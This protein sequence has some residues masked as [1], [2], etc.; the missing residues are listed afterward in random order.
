MREKPIL[1]EK[2][3]ALETAIKNLGYVS[4][5]TDETSVATQ[6]IQAEMVVRKVL[7]NLQEQAARWQGGAR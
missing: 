4:Y 1:S 3:A 2:I 6:L 7:E 5:W